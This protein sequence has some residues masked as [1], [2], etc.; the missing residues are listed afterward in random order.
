LVRIRLQRTGRT[1]RPFYR[2][3][4]TDGRQRRDGAAIE[5]LGWYDPLAKEADKQLNLKEDR[6]KYWLSVGAQPSDTMKDFLAKRNLIDTTAWEAER[7][8]QRDRVEAAKAA[9]ATPAAEGEAKP[10]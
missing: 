3:Q 10:A 2:I 7:K 1:H 6:L 5:L 9:A 4:V 8:R